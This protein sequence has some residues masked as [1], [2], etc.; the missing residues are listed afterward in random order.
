M[1][2]YFGFFFF[3]WCLVG[4]FCRYLLNAFGVWC[5]LILVLSIC[6]VDLSIRKTG[7]LKTPST[8]GLM[9]IFVFK[10]T[11]VI[12]IKLGTLDFGCMYN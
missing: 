5:Q 2:Y 10:S 7:I 12:L 4:I 11:S 3:F 6:P 1:A 8:D 9:L